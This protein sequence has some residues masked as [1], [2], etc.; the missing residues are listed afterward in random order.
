MG[1]HPNLREKLMIL[2]ESDLQ[3][4]INSHSTLA[5]KLG[6]ARQ[7]INKWINGSD[8]HR[9][10]S[11]PPLQLQRIAKLFHLDAEWFKAPLSEFEQLFRSRSG[12]VRERGSTLSRQR[13]DGQKLGITTRWEYLVSLAEL[14]VSNGRAKYAR[15]YL[16]EAAELGRLNGLR[17]DSKR[18]RQIEKKIAEQE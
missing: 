11:A 1:M 8:S 6:I 17:V 16:E 5:K 10:D 18:I 15:E 14:H 13:R 4:E 9:A 3:P 12:G 2:Y 7:N